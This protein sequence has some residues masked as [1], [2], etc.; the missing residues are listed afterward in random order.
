MAKQRYINTKF[1]SDDYIIQKDII[2]R[3]LFLYFLTNEHTSISGIYELGVGAIARETGIEREAIEKMMPRFI[4]KIYYIDGWVY[5]KNF[6]KNQS[7]SDSIKK[8]IEK[9]RKKIPPEIMEK[10]AKIK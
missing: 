1:W 5:I 4:G 3:Y 8:G 6:S 9:E 7:G 2:E 10:I